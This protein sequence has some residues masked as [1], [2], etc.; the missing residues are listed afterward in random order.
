[1]SVTPPANVLL[2]GASG[3]L[4][5]FV[6]ERLCA[7]GYRLRGFDRANPPADRPLAEFIRGDITS[8]GDVLRAVEGQDAVVHLVALVRGR[9]EQPLERFVDVMVKGTWLVVDAAAEAGVR[10]LVNVSS[11]VAVGPPAATSTPCTEAAPP[12]LGG[13]DLYY[14]LSKW[15]GEEIVR[16]YRQARG[17]SAVSLRPGV[18]AGD[19]VNPGPVAPD[20]GLPRWFN[21]VDPRD[22]AQAI[23][24]ALQATELSLSSYFVV[25]DHPESAYAID[26]ARRDLGFAPVHNWSGLRR[27]TAGADEEG[28]G[29]RP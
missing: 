29:G 10:R 4:A 21:Y 20:D 25:A 18:I 27:T 24:G 11:I 2:V 6:A 19:G 26:A 1:M 12:G 15:L 17:L 9:R 5:S 22:V 7:D 14:Q 8:A 28:G 16:V 13:P 3:Y 23:S